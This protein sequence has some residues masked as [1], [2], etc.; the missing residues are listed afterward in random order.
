MV[1]CEL[2]SSIPL[3][4]RWVFQTLERIA[5]GETVSLVALSAQYAPDL[6]DS[7]GAERIL[8]SLHD[9]APVAAQMLKLE[10]E[11]VVPRGTVIG[12]VSS[13]SDGR[14]YRWEFDIESDRICMQMLAKGPLPEYRDRV[15]AGPNARV[16]VRDYRTIGPVSAHVLLLHSYGADVG[17]WDMVVPHIDD[18]V[19]VRALD[20]RGHGRSDLHYG[21]RL[22]G[23]IEDIAVATKDVPAAE[24]IVVGHSLGGYVAVEYAARTPCRALIAFDGPTSVR[25]DDT[26]EEI[27]AAPEP[28][29]S[30]LAEHADID[31][32]R[33][34]ADL[35][36]PSLFV[37]S[38]GHAEQPE[39]DNT[40]TKRQELAARTTKHGHTVRW[41]DAGHSFAVDQPELSAQMINDFLAA[42]NEQ[43]EAATD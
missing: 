6:L 42:L 33:L 15:I 8:A 19:A 18:G 28:L 43:R 10:P 22:N 35:T 37:F 2:S 24:L 26:K 30:V 3:S 4:V 40:I 12:L 7:V 5:A 16:L 27:A 21:Y 17:C 29:R 39:P 38:C 34:V 36:T 31:Y 25:R 1:E 9:S 32:G 11:F 23:C 20:I 13:Q 41:V 14:R